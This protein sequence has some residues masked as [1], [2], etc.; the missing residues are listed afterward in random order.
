M[1]GV[2][3]LMIPIIAVILIFGTPIAAIFT[4]H[5]R[6]MAELLN[7]PRNEGDQRLVHELHQL[8][9]ELNDMRSV[10]H[11]QQIALDDLRSLPVYQNAENSPENLNA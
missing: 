9:S 11:E 2:M 5:Q 8:R 1:E 10:L 7:Q 6:K 3:A 4:H